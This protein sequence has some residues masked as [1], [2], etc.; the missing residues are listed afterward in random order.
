MLSAGTRV[1]L[2]SASHMLTLSSYT[3][4]IVKPSD[5]LGYLVIRLCQPAWY[6]NADGTTTNLAEIVEDEDNL[7]VLPA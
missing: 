2:R 4:V 7:E 6:L 3:G 5:S 1:R